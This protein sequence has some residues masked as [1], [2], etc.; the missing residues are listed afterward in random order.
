MSDIQRNKRQGDN[1]RDK[2]IKERSRQGNRLAKEVPSRDR[3]RRADIEF[4][5]HKH[6]GVGEIKSGVVVTE[7]DVDQLIDTANRFGARY[8]ELIV[9]QD[10]R[11]TEG[12]KDL[13]SSSGVRVVRSKMKP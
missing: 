5:D 8:K 11:F 9:A 3:K 13:V 1:F 6:G 12:A 7:N 10:A 2:V 4:I